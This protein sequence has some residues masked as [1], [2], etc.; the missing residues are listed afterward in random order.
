MP[1]WCQNTVTFFHEDPEMVRRVVAGYTGNG[2]MQEFHPCPQDLIDTMAGSHLP[3]S[4]E[5]AQL[6]A[7]EQANVELYGFKNWYDWCVANW[8]TKWDITSSGNGDPAVGDDGLTE[9]FSFDSAWSPPL[10]FYK[11]MEEM[12]FTV[13]AFYYEPG[14]AFCGRY[15]EGVDD[16]H[17]IRGNSDWV[18][19]N[20]P[21]A[22]VEMF[23]ISDNMSMWEQE[24]A[25]ENGET[26]QDARSALMEAKLD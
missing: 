5:Q 20:I 14:C 9:Q 13:D 15:S 17:D 22:I 16:Y 2:I 18:E 10:E 11:K 4:P 3:G 19:K 21:E 25:A 12:G 6:E 24:E 8:G 26:E 1:N 23:A 7:R